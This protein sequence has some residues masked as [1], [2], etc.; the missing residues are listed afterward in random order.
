MGVNTTLAAA[1]TA[2]ALTASA[3]M[4]AT[5]TIS[6]D[7]DATA[8]VGVSN[9]TAGFSY[10]SMGLTTE[11][12]SVPGASTSPF[13]NTARYGDSYFA[14]ANGGFMDIVL[15]H[16]ANSLSFLWGSPDSFN[17]VQV[18]LNDATSMIFSR[19]NIPMVSSGL[20]SN[21]VTFGATAGTKITSVNFS[22]SGTAFEFSNIRPSEVP[23]PAGGA[24][25]LAGLAGV[26][27]LRRRNKPL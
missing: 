6:N 9:S 25:L 21:Y 11:T 20:A 17:Y 8:A 13:N 15:T 14:L 16:A 23:V 7:G 5:I 19:G 10:T 27:A 1:M 26:A 24:L 12:N 3:S 4:A 22:T 18:F 2:L